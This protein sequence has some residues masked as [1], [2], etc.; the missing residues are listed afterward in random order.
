MKCPHC[1][2]HVSVFSRSINKF[3]S[4]QLCPKC[5]QPVKTYLSLKWAAILFIPVFV[6]LQAI[7]LL[8]I[9]GGFSSS[10]AT[11]F[12]CGLLVVLSMRL[13]VPDDATRS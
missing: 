3:G 9:N 4:M 13:K 11:G 2:Q 7:K 1:S 5:N 10:L 12:A 6:S 8:F